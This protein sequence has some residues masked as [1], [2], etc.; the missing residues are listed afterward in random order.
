MVI[1]MILFYFTV[2]TIVFFQ[3]S[4]TEYFTFESETYFKRESFTSE[5]GFNVAFALIEYGE[6]QKEGNPPI[7]DESYGVLK[8]Y[9]Y[10]WNQE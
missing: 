6:N 5:D 8:A 9:H 3:K 1:S 10:S 7:D 2:K 4:D